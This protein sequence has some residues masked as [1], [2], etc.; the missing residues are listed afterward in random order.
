MISLLMCIVLQAI[1]SPILV[2]ANWRSTTNELSRLEAETAMI[3]A[4]LDLP[5]MNM[6][7]KRKSNAQP[8]KTINQEPKKTKSGM[9][10]VYVWQNY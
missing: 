3:M 10:I 6:G 1:Y 7:H 8:S 4:M 5:A 2:E 9:S